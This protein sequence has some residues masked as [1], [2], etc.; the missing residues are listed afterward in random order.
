V[1]LDGT[2]LHCAQR[3]EEEVDGAEKELEGSEN[4]ISSTSGSYSEVAVFGVG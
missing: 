1:Y 3:M 4:V 2:R